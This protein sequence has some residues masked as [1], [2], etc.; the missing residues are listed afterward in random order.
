MEEQPA[1]AD[2]V[3]APVGVGEGVAC[4]DLLNQAGL[5]RGLLQELEPG[6]HGG[7]EILDR[8]Y[9]AGRAAV[10]FVRRLAS[11]YHAQERADVFA[12]AVGEQRDLG[13]GGDARQ[14][15][16]AKAQ[17]VQVIQVIQRGDLA[18]GMA[19]E[20]EAGFG[21]RNPHAVVVDADERPATFT[22]FDADIAERPRQCC[23]P[24]AP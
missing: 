19:L 22:D 21:V 11:V 23:F 6:R 12:V 3:E 15:F 9:R 13:D 24:V 1:I 20:R 17:R 18:G 5:G 14:R 7:E 2:Q 4:D 16:A 10:R 8:Q